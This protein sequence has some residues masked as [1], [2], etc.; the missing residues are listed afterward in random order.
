MDERALTGEPRPAPRTVLWNDTRCQ[1]ALVKLILICPWRVAAGCSGLV[2]RA[3]IAGVMTQTGRRGLEGRLSDGSPWGALLDAGCR[4]KRGRRC[5]RATGKGREAGKAGSCPP[6]RHVFSP[7]GAGPPPPFAG[8]GYEGDLGFR[9]FGGPWMSGAAWDL[10]Q[11]TVTTGGLTAGRGSGSGIRPVRG[12]VRAKV[13]EG[14][15]PTGGTSRGRSWAR[16]G[17]WSR[18]RPGMGDIPTRSPERCGRSDYPGT[19]PG[20]DAPAAFPKAR[21]V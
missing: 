10:S 3:M 1:C 2:G 4:G 14:R 8:G 12:G 19:G 6:A 9:L 18:G 17:R 5:E 16:A 20:D 15:W 13:R 21:A 11:G 7:M